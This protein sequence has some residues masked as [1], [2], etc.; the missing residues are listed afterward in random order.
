MP[1]PVLINHLSYNLENTEEFLYCFCIK[2]I[3]FDQR[4]YNSLFL[5]L[6]SSVSLCRG[7]QDMRKRGGRLT[8][9]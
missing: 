8:Y 6:E 1:S 4:N 2:H 9:F 7:G 5:T 3:L